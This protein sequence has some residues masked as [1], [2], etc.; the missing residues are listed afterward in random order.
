LPVSLATINV[1]TSLKNTVTRL[2]A[3]KNMPLPEGVERLESL[4]EIK[5]A[6]EARRDIATGRV[7][8]RAIEE[9]GPHSLFEMVTSTDYDADYE[10]FQQFQRFKDQRRSSRAQITLDYTASASSSSSSAPPAA[11]IL[12]Y[13]QK[14]EVTRIDMNYCQICGSYLGHEEINL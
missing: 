10:E 5:A 4:Q 1:V 11:S 8:K 13:C 3:T 12:A 2:H 9:P 14:C 7:K 6:R